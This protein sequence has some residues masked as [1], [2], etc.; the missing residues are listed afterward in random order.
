MKR[1]NKREYDINTL[2]RL[3]IH[4]FIYNPNKIEYDYDLDVDNKE[5]D[6]TFLLSSESNIILL[7]NILL[8]IF[9]T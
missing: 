8:I 3:F 6:I 1:E 5:N 7:T 4:K 2:L 9:K